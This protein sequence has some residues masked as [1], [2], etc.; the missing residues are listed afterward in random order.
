MLSYFQHFGEAQFKPEFKLIENA[1]K[2]L[3]FQ[4][5]PHHA[6]HCTGPFR[7][8]KERPF[9]GEVLHMFLHL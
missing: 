1:G 9:K 5:P 6:L 8:D 7:Q 3:I 2:K 4:Q